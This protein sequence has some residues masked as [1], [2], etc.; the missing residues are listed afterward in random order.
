[1]VGPPEITLYGI[2][3][4]QKALHTISSITHKLAPNQFMIEK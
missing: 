1:M 2:D 3:G 4:L